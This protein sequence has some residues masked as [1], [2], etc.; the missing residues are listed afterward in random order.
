M[1]NLTNSQ[2]KEGHVVLDFKSGLGTSHTHGG[3]QATVNFEDSK[4]V[5]DGRIR[6]IFESIKRD[7]LVSS[8]RL[9]TIPFPKVEIESLS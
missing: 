8:R 7:D 1:L 3:T 4:F 5:E 9:D 2:I 6:S